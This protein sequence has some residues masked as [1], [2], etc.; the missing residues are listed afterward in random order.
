MT[1]S[2][3]CL[4]CSTLLTAV[5]DSHVLVKTANVDEL[6]NALQDEVSCSHGKD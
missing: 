2:A 4:D 1:R 6:R 3:S 5:D